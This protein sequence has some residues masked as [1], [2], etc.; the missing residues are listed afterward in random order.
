MALNVHDSN[1]NSPAVDYDVVVVGLGPVGATLANLL[2]LQGLRILVLEREGEA[3]A[4]PRAVHFDDE[5]MRVFQAAGLTDELMPVVAPSKG[6]RY[7]DAHGKVII[8]SP[9]SQELTHH[10]WHHG[11]RFHQPELEEILTDGLK[12]WPNVE[13]K[14]RSEVFAL[15]QSERGVYARFEDLSSGRL[16]SVHASFVVGC[17]GARSTVRRFIGSELL[18]LG[19]HERW[20]VVDLLLKVPRPD[21]G[22]F[23]VQHCNPARSSTYVCGVGNRR[24]WEI[25]LHQGESSHEMM[26]PSRVWELLAHWLTPDDAEIERQAVYTFHSAIAATWRAGRLL[27]AGDSAHQTPPFLGQGMCAGIRDA[28]NLAWKIAAV[29][30]GRAASALLDTYQQERASH[31]REYIELAVKLG[32]VINTT[33]TNPV[34][35][36][37]VTPGNSPMRLDRRKPLLGRGFAFGASELIG[38]QIP[39][40][41]LMDGQRLDDDIGPGFCLL[42]RTDHAG[43]LA[44]DASALLQRYHVPIVS[45]PSPGLQEWLAQT[46]HVAVLV[47]PDRYAFGGADDE[48]QLS[49]LLAAAFEHTPQSQPTVGLSPAESSSLRGH[50]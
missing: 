11:Y 40:P 44:A 30:Q 16:R 20:L 9:T 39:Q 14:R 38:K 23:S 27:L 29:L 46:G 2:G 8:E 22:E 3:Y 31:V 32:G 4:L 25:R 1:S 48:A 15:D 34:L 19:F 49:A 37:T 12:R 26:Q 17:D 21:L 24:R 7:I 5:C 33:S 50:A 43:T 42:V 28:S 10:G 41:V 13:V 18:D 47:R 45:D 6:M 36:N 35:P